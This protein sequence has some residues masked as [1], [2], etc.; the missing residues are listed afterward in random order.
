MYCFAYSTTCAPVTFEFELLFSCFAVC[1]S[2]LF[3]LF[4]DS[5]LV[6]TVSFELVLFVLSIPPLDVVSGSLV[7]DIYF[8]DTYPT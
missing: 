5:V 2:L 6:S 8:F 4:E 3:S 7:S 1:S